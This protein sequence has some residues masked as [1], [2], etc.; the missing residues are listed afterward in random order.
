MNAAPHASPK[1]LASPDSRKRTVTHCAVCGGHR[2]RYLFSI[3]EHRL[4]RCGEC[5]FT[6]LNPQP[7]D[8]DLSALEN[9]GEPVDAADAQ[10]RQRTAVRTLDELAAYAGS[11]RG[12]LLEIGCGDGTL[13]IAA[14]QRGFAVTG[15]E[16]SASAC[17]RARSRLLAEGVAGEIVHGDVD[18]VDAR[19]GEFDACIVADLL[20]RVRDPRQFIQQLHRLL[21]PG[22]VL[23]VA[24]PSLDSWS[25]QLRSARWAEFK[26]EHLF[27]FNRRSLESLLFAQGF[28]G[29]T[30]TPDHE[31]LSRDRPRHVE[32]D[33]RSPESAPRTGSL[34]PAPLRAW[35]YRLATSGMVVIG[36]RADRPAR[37]LLSI[38]VPAYNE[39]ATFRT[40][41]ARL[42]AH[43]FPACDVEFIVVESNSTDGTR[44]MVNAYARHPGVRVLLEDRPRGKGH[45]VRTGLRAAQG[46]FIAIQDAD[47]EY[48]LDD[49]DSLLEPL[50]NN[51]EAFVLGAR[52]G[53]RSWKMRQFAG[54]P[55]TSGLLN[56]GHWFFTALLNVSLG[57]RLKDPFTMYKLFRHDC[58][59]DLEF[60]ANRFDFDWELVIK[61][62]R[63][64]YIP[65][66]IPVNY[67]S[68][69]FHEGKKVSVI[70]DPL[71]WFVALAKFRF[72]RLGQRAARPDVTPEPR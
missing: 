26:P 10:L 71:S 61:L 40:A 31:I 54:Q 6:L 13:L 42:L 2:F 43:P 22:G 1:D 56:F 30:W 3:E 33:A 20:E 51:R 24:T 63:K 52:H 35:K 47:L 19:A 57:V 65:I 27:Y 58:I 72:Q 17:E 37:P 44:E 16:R 64:G 18:A 60:E 70:R 29:L 25:A 14:A 34:L 21:R 36:R 5:N 45:A 49:Y 38:I 11:S 66:E 62:I 9:T 28:R 55:L 39:A 53:G 67:R 23:Y 15:V 41:F 46:D 4:V 59:H 48:D 8:H 32:E 68:R 7:S 69:S 50:L 12:K